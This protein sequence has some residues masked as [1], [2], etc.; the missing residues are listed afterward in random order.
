MFVVFAC[1]VR[2]RC[3]AASRGD[4]NDGF[5]GAKHHLARTR[6]AQLETVGA[7]RALQVF[8]EKPFQ[9]TRG[10]LYV[11]GEFVDV[12]IMGNDEHDARQ[13]ISLES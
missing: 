11:A 7:G 8:I 10:K 12:M 2:H 5:F 1:E 4:I 13:A 6:Q 3:E 9:L